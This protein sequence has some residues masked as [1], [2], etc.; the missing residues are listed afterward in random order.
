[1]IDSLRV[2]GHAGFF[3]LLV[4]A[5]TKAM[6]RSNA[7]IC[8]HFPYLVHSVSFAF[9]MAWPKFICGTG[10]SASG[11]AVFSEFVSRFPF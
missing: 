8:G 11:R 4:A 3:L 6:D 1:V 7:T 9:F 5:Q 10:K 2:F